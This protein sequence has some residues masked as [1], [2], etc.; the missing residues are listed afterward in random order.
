MWCCGT[1]STP[2]PSKAN[3][4]PGFLIS[5]AAEGQAVGAVAQE[6]GPTTQQA[7]QQKSALVGECLDVVV[8]MNERSIPFVLDS[9]SQVT[10]LG[11]SLFAK[12]LEGAGMT[13]ANKLP[14]LTLRA[15]NG[16]KIPYLGYALVNCKVV[17][18]SGKGVII[19]D[20]ECLGPN[21]GM[22]GMNIIQ[23]VW[24]ALNQGNHPG[25]AAF[26]TIMPP[27][28]GRLWPQAFA[29]CR[30][31]AA[32]CPLPPYQGVAKL[33]RQQ[34]ISPVMSSLNLSLTVTQSGVW[35]GHWPP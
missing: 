20:D 12:H 15:A 9:G 1:Y 26:K 17:H 16:L 33:P 11:R 8:E 30:K 18:V 21:K 5:P 28:E 2:V 10:L 3:W 6:E 25:L 35:D 32:K 27:L 7:A 14:W 22:L 31:I 19:V 23:A 4:A 13:A 34:P 24:S 29:E